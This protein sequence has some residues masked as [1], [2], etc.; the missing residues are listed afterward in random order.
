MG[1]V[2]SA[3]DLDLGLDQLAIRVIAGQTLGVMEHHQGSLRIGVRPYRDLYIMEPVGILWDLRAQ[4][5]IAHGVVL[6]HN[7]H[8]LHTQDL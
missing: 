3:A 8:L 6:G 7:P 4:A 2:R 5:L 1:R